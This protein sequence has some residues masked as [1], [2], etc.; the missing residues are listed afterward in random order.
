MSMYHFY[1]LL[2]VS[3]LMNNQNQAIKIQKRQMNTFKLSFFK[4]AEILNYTKIA[5]GHLTVVHKR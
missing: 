4:K 2:H 3:A 1:C 5:V